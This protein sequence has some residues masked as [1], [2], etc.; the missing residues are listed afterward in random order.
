MEI[1]HPLHG[2]YP[3]S[4]QEL[5]ELN[6]RLHEFEHQKSGA[7]LVWLDRD[8]ENKTFCIGFR[9]PPED[10]TGV[11]HILEHS[12]LC[13]SERY[14]VKEPFVELMKSSMNT[15]LNAITFPD[16]TIYPVSSRNDQDFLNLM[17]VYLDAVLHPRI[18]HSPDIFHQEGWHYEFDENGSPSYKGVV[19]NEMKGALSTP[20]RL[21][22]NAIVHNLF[23]DTCYGYV[24]GGDPAYIPDLTYEYFIDCHRRFYHPSN[25]YIILDGR[26]NLD[27][28]LNIIND[29]YLSAY[30]K[31]PTDSEIKTQAPV[32]NTGRSIYYEVS[33]DAS[34]VN[35]ASMAWGFAAGTF[36]SREK[37][38]AAD[39]LADVLCGSNQAPLKEKLLSA[40]LAQDVRLTLSDQ[41]LQPYIVLEVR[42]CDENRADEIQSSIFSVIRNLA[43]TGL[44]HEQLT[45]ALANLEFKL[46]ER[47]FGRLPRGLNFAMMIL[48]QW[49][50][51]GNPAG[52]LEVGE[53]FST[54]NT[55]LHEGYFEQLLKELFL[56]NSHYCQITMLPSPTL[57]S[58]KIA[59]EQARL[60]N[61]SDAWILE[62]INALKEAQTKLIAWQQ[63]EDTPEA[64]A[65]LPHLRLSDIESEPAPIPTAVSTLSECTLLCHDLSSNGIDY[66]NLYF[67]ISDLTESELSAA[68]L[69]C[70][71]L[72]SID[73]ERYTVSELQKQ[74]RLTCGNLIFD[75]LSCEYSNNPLACRTFL[76]VSFSTLNAKLNAAAAL[77]R[78]IIC[79]S[80]FN[81]SRKVQE[82]LNQLYSRMERA[83]VNMGNSFA[84][85]RLAAAS[86][87]SGVSD[88]YTGG[89]AFI[90]WLKALKTDFEDR[91][92]SLITDLSALCS[93]IFVKE[94]LTISLTG[95][96]PAA[97]SI[98][99]D[100]ILKQLPLGTASGPCSLKPWGK[101]KE[102]I[103]IPAGVSFAGLGANLSDFGGQYNGQ[104]KV[105]ARTA[106]LSYLWNVI[107]VQG[108]AYGTGL[109]IS[110]CGNACF[111]SYRD[112]SADRSLTCYRQTA[113]FLEQFCA[114]NPDLTGLIVGTIAES[115]P[116]RLPQAMGKTGDLLWLKGSSHQE[117]CKLR[118]EILST[119]PD[120]IKAFIPAL[121][122]LS[123]EG[124]ICV[125]GGKEKVEACCSE[126]D[127]ICTL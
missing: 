125:I 51:G 25:S 112:P 44:D 60:A 46:R 52:E 71:L 114:S 41:V 123:T 118:Q 78:E 22:R 64:L 70:T 58:E 82:I 109:S 65:K 96:N 113:D 105:M 27:S 37:L 42:N 80:K 38:L 63:S 5:P 26:I 45:A 72:G 76:S 85:T 32:I 83:I 35:R 97:A 98:L 92:A 73:T 95:Q 93:R 94:R 55:K 126:L 24:S 49:L 61:E 23:P 34:L 99:D 89:V 104:A 107:R 7:R 15:F 21:L 2:F 103:V 36:D 86:S 111:H 1:K 11:F 68:S 31:Q 117:R 14:P 120:D 88:E 56:E 9:T 20:E 101:R 43:E 47:D 16:K 8:D 67:D 53:L 62:D 10:H 116:L 6:G 100:Q 122:R 77:V 33:A 30:D 29:E 119:T 121:R 28:V 84:R 75:T 102:G 39:I 127:T 74:N 115:D 87:V 40:G 69:L 48:G 50:Y 54:L 17:R 4:V 18:Y 110:E 19:F 57:G 66:V 124:S 13:G 108:G 79:T 3:I 90:Q 81:D 59:K 106:F 91:S 12:V